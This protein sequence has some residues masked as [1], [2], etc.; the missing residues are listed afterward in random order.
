MPNQKELS[1]EWK[2]GLFWFCLRQHGPVYNYMSWC[3]QNCSQWILILNHSRIIGQIVCKSL[4]FVVMTRKFDRSPRFLVMGF[5]LRCHANNQLRTVF[6]MHQSWSQMYQTYI[7]CI[8]LISSEIYPFQH[9]FNCS[10]SLVALPF[11]H[12]LWWFHR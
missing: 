8:F 11:R 6:S 10:K 1:C 2:V 7:D 3:L 5:C 12:S 9:A 4:F